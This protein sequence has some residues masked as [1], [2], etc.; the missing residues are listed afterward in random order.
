MDLDY[1]KL[2]DDRRSVTGY[3]NFLAEGSVA[4]QSKTQASVALSTMD[5]TYMTLA[6]EVQEVE[7]HRMVFEELGFSVAQP[8]VIK[9]DIRHATFCRPRGEPFK[10]QTYRCKVSLRQ[11]RDST[12]R[13]QS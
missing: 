8:T 10:D 11:R 7:H 5:E 12:W 9:E 13:R 4:W 2:L 1:A 3:V 6:A